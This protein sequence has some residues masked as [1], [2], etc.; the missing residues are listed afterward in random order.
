VGNGAI[1]LISYDGNSIGIVIKDSCAQEKIL[2]GIDYW[3]A[4]FEKEIQC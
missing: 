3:L 2:L 1:L 4:Y